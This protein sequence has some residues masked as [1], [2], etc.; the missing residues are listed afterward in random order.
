MNDVITRIDQIT[1]TGM[2]FLQNMTVLIITIVIGLIVGLFGL[3]LV[4]V[5]AAFM[6]FL[7]GAAAGG[8]GGGS[9][10]L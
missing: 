1:G 4:R 6:G 3:K 2:L 9:S 10:P 8:G 5:W 7:L